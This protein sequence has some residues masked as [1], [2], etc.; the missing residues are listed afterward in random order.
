MPREICKL[1]ENS[2]SKLESNSWQERRDALELIS[3]QLKVSTLP[4]GLL[5]QVTKGLCQFL[6]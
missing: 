5:G 1:D 4:S 3:N 6:F 2:L